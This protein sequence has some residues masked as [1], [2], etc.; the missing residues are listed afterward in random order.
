[1]ESPSIINPEPHPRG[2]SLCF[3]ISTLTPYVINGYMN[4]GFFGLLLCLCRDDIESAYREQELYLVLWGMVWGIST[5]LARGCKTIAKD[6]IGFKVSL[7]SWILPYPIPS[8][9][10]VTFSGLYKA[11][12]S[13][14][15]SHATR[16]FA[17]IHASH[18]QFAMKV[19]RLAD[20]NTH[21]SLSR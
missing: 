8:T 5:E 17:C 9:G 20:L 6:S 2:Y 7:C 10:S 16:C 11:E 14:S 3:L 15:W 21:I 4:E 19:L 1:M 13:V 18:P 12:V